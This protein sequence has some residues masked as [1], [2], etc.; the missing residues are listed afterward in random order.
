M[1]SF[2]GEKAAELSSR[3]EADSCG[4]ILVMLDTTPDPSM[5]EEGVAREVVNRVQKFR[6]SAGLKVGSF[7]RVEKMRSIYRL[8]IIKNVRSSITHKKNIKEI[9]S[10][11]FIYESILIKIYMK[12]FH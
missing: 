10:S 9:L 4:D 6:K 5:I 8:L 11:T 3:Y 2:A 7:Y 1:Y 12:I